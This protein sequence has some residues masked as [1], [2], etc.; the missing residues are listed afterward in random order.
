[1]LR[2]GPELL[3]DVAEASRREWLLADGRGGYAATSVLG[4]NTRREHGLLVASLEAPVRRMVLLSRLEEAVLVSGRRH[5][6]GSNRYRDVVHPRGHELARDF[7]L[8]PLPT[9]AYEVEGRTISRTVARVHGESAVVVLYEQDGTDP[10]S[11]EVR[12]LLAYRDVEALQ[13]ENDRVR[14]GAP[15]VAGDPVVC[16]YEGCP[17]L[18]LRLTGGR[19]EPDALWYRGFFYERDLEEGRDHVEDLFSPGRFV[20]E[21]RPRA[22]VAFFAWLNRI[23]PLTDGGSRVAAERRRLRAAADAPEGALADLRRAADAFVVRRPDGVPAIVSHYPSG[24]VTGISPLL[25]L[26]GL[27]LAT[28][29]HDE[30]RALLSDFASRVS[31]GRTAEGGAVDLETGLWW[32]M[33][34][35]RFVEASGDR[36]FVRARLQGALLA[37]LEGVRSAAGSLVLGPDGLVRRAAEGGPP[38][39]GTDAVFA[40]RPPFAIEMQAA[41]YN[42]LV[43]G[44]DLA[45]GAGQTARAGEWTALASRVREAVLRLFW[46]ER[47]G[48]Q[49]DRVDDSGPDFTLQPRQVYALALPHALLPRDRAQ[50]ILDALRRGLLTP[51]GLRSG[52]TAWPFLGAAYFDALIRVHGEAAKPDAWR[53]LDGLVPRLAGP[54]LGQ[55]PDAYDAEAPHL[56]RGALASALNVAEVLRLWTRLGRRPTPRPSRPS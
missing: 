5:D 53:W 43:I 27:L 2:L 36:E 42:A 14:P 8:D 1:M 18:A 3:L 9:L 22:T 15:L 19:W 40:A 41:W 55:L 37:V 52:S 11:I 48:H 49:A 16:P 47:H 30:A 39:R 29:R 10:V 51:V 24:D 32:T 46:S 56:P 34:V 7:A 17:P 31:A 45:R 6:L 54:R 44:A 23:P 35:E 21:L 38:A 13:R 12:P 4:L 26:P 50:R 33:A 20:A 28:G 25:A